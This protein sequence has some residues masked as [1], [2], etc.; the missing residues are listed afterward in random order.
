MN[1]LKKQI[2]ALTLT[3]LP[4][5]ASGAGS[6]KPKK[7]MNQNQAPHVAQ[8]LLVSFKEGVKDE[9]VKNILAK[10]SLKFLEKLGNINLYLVEVP[11]NKELSAMQSQLKSEPSIQYSEPNTVM[12]TFKT[13]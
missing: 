7:P 3:G 9:E 11:A 13:K 6:E 4:L 1:L 12:K 5:L 8:Q 10:H 2:L